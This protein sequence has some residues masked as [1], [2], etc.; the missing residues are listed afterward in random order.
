MAPLR[1]LLE[2]RGADTVAPE[3]GQ[4]LDLDERGIRPLLG[5]DLEDGTCDDPTVDARDQRAFGLVSLVLPDRQ[6]LGGGVREVL[7]AGHLGFHGVPH[8]D[9]R[10]EVRAA[11]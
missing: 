5:L 11:G 10:R 4:D 2:Q 1:Q 7:R 8:I 9:H 6:H 3:L